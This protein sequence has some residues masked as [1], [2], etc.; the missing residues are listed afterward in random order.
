MAKQGKRDLIITEA[1][2]LFR[3]KGFVATTMREIGEQM[4]LEAASLYNYIRSKEEILEVIC[5]KVAHEY[6]AHISQIEATD[7]SNVQKLKDLIALHVRMIIKSPNEVSVANNEWKNLSDSKK[8]EYKTIRDGYEDRIAALL[9]DGM[10]C[11]EFKKVNISVAVYTLL[12][13]LR[14]IE[15]WYKPERNVTA[16]ELEHD[17]TTLLIGG[18]IK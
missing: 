18:F 7:A 3:Q 9:K 6:L 15:L 4:K 12:S 17:V 8:E 10:S 11:L 13:S 14:W 5:F 1:A 2:I 16:E